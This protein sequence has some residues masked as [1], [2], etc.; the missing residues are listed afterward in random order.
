MFV[1]LPGMTH[2]TVS[3]AITATVTLAGAVAFAPSAS[4]HSQ[5][6]H[7]RST[8]VSAVAE[9]GGLTARTILRGSDLGLT[10]PD[11]LT[12]I[13]NRLFVA[14][15][16][17]VPSTGGGPGTPTQSTVVELTTMGHV[18]TRWQLTGKC[19]GLTADPAHQRLIA[20]V[21]EDGNSSLYTIGTGEDPT[22]RHYSY[23]ASPLPHGGGTDSITVYQGRIL[24]AASAPGSGTF[25][26][27]MYEVS[28]SG[29]VAH[30][31][32]V[33]FYDS[34]SA[35]VANSGAA[36]KVVNLALTDPD[37]SSAV[38]ADSPRF[39]GQLMLTSQG[40]QQQIFASRLA[41][42]DQVL[43]VLNLSQ[44][45]DDTAW[46]T[47]RRGI[48]VATDAA[49][50]TVVVISGRFLPGTA[51]TAVTPA[52]ANSAPPNPGPNYLGTIDLSTGTVTAA[53]TTGDPLQP[54]GLLFVP[55]DSFSS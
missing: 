7:I 19:D 51:L 6:A 39:A 14:F 18:I 31:A 16:N 3:V 36:H 11:D 10:G 12:R 44:S 40:D 33:P 55:V 17:G 41:T 5:R 1:S 34:S 30:L 42:G 46:A 32:T 21:N 20:T 50:N 43:H 25:G 23:D 53:V 48:L 47:A 26:P 13:G 22:V 4:A 54:K 52:N 24:V 9:A 29:S 49:D 37:S 8:R 27:A 28:L 35:V 38:P 2:R 15:Q 45:V